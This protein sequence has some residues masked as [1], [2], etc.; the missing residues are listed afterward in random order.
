[1]TTPKNTTDLDAIRPLL[2]KALVA[3]TPHASADVCAVATNAVVDSGVPNGR[4]PRVGSRWRVE[5]RRGV[6]DQ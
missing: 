3:V 6:N 1:M 4:T 5:A 2:A